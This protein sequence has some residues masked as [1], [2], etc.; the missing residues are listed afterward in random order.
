[1]TSIPQNQPHIPQLQIDLVTILGMIA[2][3]LARIRSCDKCRTHAVRLSASIA[4]LTSEI[5]R[6]REALIRERLVSANLRAAIRSALGAQ[7]DGEPD[8]L[9]YLRDEIPGHDARD[10]RGAY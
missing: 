6:L 5:A 2:G 8:P 1:M 7:T 3:E 4:E 9:A 10:D